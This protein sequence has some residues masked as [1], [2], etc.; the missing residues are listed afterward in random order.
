MV[1][2]SRWEAAKA[3]GIIFMATVVSK[4]LGFGREAA[5]AAGFGASAAMDAYL[6]A[7][8]VPMMLLGLVGAALTTAAIPVFTAYG[9]AEKKEELSRVIWSVFHAVLLALSALTLV[10]IFVSPL[11]IRLVAPGFSPAQAELAAGLSRIIM[12]T[13]LVLGLSGWATAVLQARKS[14]VAPAVVGIPSNICLIIFA[15]WAARHGGIYALAWLTV[16]ATSTQL[17]VQ[18]PALFRLGFRYRPALDLTH[19]AVRRIAVLMTPVILGVAIGQINTVVDRILASG[20]SEGSIA[21]LSYANRVAMLPIGFLITPILTVFYPSLAAR[22]SAGERVRF[23]ELVEEGLNICLFL[24]VP[25]TV[26]LALL[27]VDIVRFVFERGAFDARATQATAIAAL[28]YGLGLLPIAWRDHLSRAYYALQD[29]TTPVLTGFA[30]IVANVILNFILVRYMAHA[31]L[32]LATTLA[33]SLGCLLLLI[34]LRRRLGGLGGKKLA[35]N[36]A[37]VLAGSLV[38]AVVVAFLQ[39]FFPWPGPAFIRLTGR[40]TFLPGLVTFAAQALRLIFFI[41]AGALTYALVIGR[42]LRIY[43]NEYR[44]QKAAFG[45]RH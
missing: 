1:W 9:T 11:I 29:T 8:V 39:R 7:Q 36:A 31:G 28:Y 20:L 24:L 35:A 38:M 45:T 41:G 30:S 2:V 27:R 32:A 13:M 22:W 5:L 33:N 17:L 14:F 4:V 43:L 21:A 10:G 26:G 23:R 6:V 3:A 16:L 19:P 37:R 15:L 44:R 42:Q 34:L 18:L 12:P 40:L 25:V